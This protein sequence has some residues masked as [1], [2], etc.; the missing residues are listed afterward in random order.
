MHR[1][2][3][4]SIS[5]LLAASGAACSSD[6]SSTDEET[7]T[8]AAGTDEAGTDE[9]GDGG[10]E[11]AAEPA[12]A[13]T[14][15]N[16]LVFTG[17]VDGAPSGPFETE[18]V[19]ADEGPHPDNTVDYDG[20]LQVAISGVE[21]EEDPQFGLSIPVGTPDL[22]EGAQWVNFSLALPEGQV[23]S[24][25]Q[26]FIDQLEFTEGGEHDGEINFIAAYDGTERLTLGTP[27]VTI[28][29]ITDEQVCGQ[30][31]MT[32]ETDL[33]SFVG[34]EGTFAADRI[35]ALEAAAEEE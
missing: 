35:Q 2:G 19:L 18:M 4:I 3:I 25:G 17:E 23:I 11:E 16:E 32:T 1:S 34:V 7:T 6:D 9:A 10:S 21:I 33:Q 29:E 27:V 14:C 24:A 8:T 22:P 20:S 5:L 30:I 12:E 26:T 15:V 13:D 31:A 28:T